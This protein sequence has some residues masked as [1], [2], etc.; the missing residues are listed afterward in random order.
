MRKIDKKLGYGLAIGFIIILF[1]GYFY[2]GRGSAAS[3]NLISVKRAD[4]VQEVSVTGNVVPVESVSLAFDITGKI[5]KFNAEV[6]DIVKSGQ[7]LAVIS[8]GD[9][10]AALN[11]ANA[12]VAAEEAGLAELKSGTRPEEIK[13]SEAEVAGARDAVA[14]AKKTLVDAIDDAYTN[15]DDA[16]RNRVDR[17]ITNVKSGSPTITFVMSDSVLEAKIEAERNY[18]EP[19]LDA[20]KDSLSDLSVT[21]DLKKHLALASTNLQYVKSLLDK[22]ATAVNV[23]VASSELAEATIETYKSEVSTGR[24]N[25]STVIAALSAADEKLKAA[26]SALAVSEQELALEKAGTIPEQIAAQEAAVAQA[27]AAAESARIALSKSYLISPIDGIVTESSLSVGEIASADTPI[28][29]VISASDFEMEAYVPEADIA[30]VKIGDM[31]RVTLDAYGS[32]VFFDAKV[33]SID[34]AETVFE[35]VSTYKT[36]FQFLVKDNR[37]KSG[38]TANIDIQTNKVENVLAIPQRSVIAREA[39]K[40]VLLDAG[41]STTETKIMTGLR[42]SDGQYEVLSGLKEGDKIVAIPE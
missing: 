36:A 1:A 6:G 39:E 2:F 10:V 12:S 3:Y 21:G 40:F 35:G 30:K 17:F 5:S 7:V 18:L 25:I 4:V 38:M 22:S 20:W 29:S 31:A 11:E 33:T 37:A 23:L 24:T 41:G 14:D 13:I 8:N 27:K 16:V 32:D 26:E 42:G 15:S 19:K 34:P 9:L 28:M